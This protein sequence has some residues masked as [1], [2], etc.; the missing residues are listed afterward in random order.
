MD[1]L[2][3]DSIWNGNEEWG[4]VDSFAGGFGDKTLAVRRFLGVG[5]V[6]VSSNGLES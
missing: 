3:R 4:C 6:R 5:A 1:L 2:D